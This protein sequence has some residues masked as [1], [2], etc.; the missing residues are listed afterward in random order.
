MTP[1]EMEFWKVLRELIPEQFCLFAKVRIADVVEVNARRY[2]K[3]YNIKFSRISQKHLD[4]VICLARNS[5]VIG[6]VEL[7]D[8]SHQRQDRMERDRFVDGCLLQAGVPLLHIGVSAQYD[9]TYIGELLRKKFN[10]DQVTTK[11]QAQTTLQ[12]E[13]KSP[14]NTLF[15]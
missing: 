2:T 15:K 3:G 14:A 13:P 11:T 10:I 12:K 9:K 7:D 8:S 6:A 4:F 5:G 1:T